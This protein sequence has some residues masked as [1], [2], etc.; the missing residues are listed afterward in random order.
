MLLFTFYILHVYNEAKKSVELEN[1]QCKHLQKIPDAVSQVNTTETNEFVLLRQPKFGKSRSLESRR[2]DLVC[3]QG[4]D[5]PGAGPRGWPVSPRQA[6]QRRGS[7][8]A[9]GRTHSTADVAKRT[10]VCPQQLHPED[11]DE[12]AALLRRSMLVD[13][14]C[15]WG[16]EPAQ[17]HHEREVPRY[18]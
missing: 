3:L 5:P 2:L 6:P 16:Q 7:L 14:S 18:G 12:E 8:V 13:G 10:P 9:H 17:A 11:S 4:R 15:S 1:E